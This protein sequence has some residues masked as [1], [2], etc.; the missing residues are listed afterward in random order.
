MAIEEHGGGHQ[1]VRFRL[2]PVWSSLTVTV[3]ILLVLAIAAWHTDSAV[4]GSILLTGTLFVVAR[5][6]QEG[7]AATQAIHAAL[8]KAD[9]GNEGRR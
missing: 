3:P 7:A 1:L 9:Q 4:V 5:T 2:W 8:P 6:L